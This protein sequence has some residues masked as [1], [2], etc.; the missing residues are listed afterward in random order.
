VIRFLKTINVYLAEIQRQVVEVYSEG[1]V[2][3]GNVR[4]WC[5]MFREGR[6]NV[7]DKE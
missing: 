3:E 2:N 5:W 4:K 7:H 1:A 6:I